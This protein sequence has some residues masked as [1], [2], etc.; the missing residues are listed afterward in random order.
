MSNQTAKFDQSTCRDPNLGQVYDKVCKGDKQC[1]NDLKQFCKTELY[2][3]R[4]YNIKV[5]LL[6]C[7]QDKNCTKGSNECIDQCA[8]TITQKYNN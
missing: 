1:I 2:T 8:K 6:K 4:D 5:D 3:A 7:F